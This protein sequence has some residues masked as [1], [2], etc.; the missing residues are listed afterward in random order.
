MCPVK[1]AG[2]PEATNDPAQRQWEDPRGRRR[3]QYAAPVRVAR[4]ARPQRRQ[5]RLRAGPMRRMH[6][7]GRHAGG[8]LVHHADLRDSRPQDN[9]ARRAGQRGA[10]GAM[11]L[12]H[13][14]DDDARPGV[15]RARA[16]RL[17]SRNPRCPRAESLPLRNAHAHPARR[18]TRRAAHEGRSEAMSGIGTPA[19]SRREFLAVGGALI[20]TFSLDPRLVAA[21]E[22]QGG[23]AAPKAATLPGDLEKFPLLDSWIRIAADGGIT[24]FTGKA[25]LGQGIKT[26]LAQIAA[27]QLAVGFERITLI[28]ADTERTPNEG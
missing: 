19:L 13:S 28:T 1:C 25:E 2:L 7:D 24:V 21:Q 20:L 8:V 22:G 17:R 26:A 15:A 12:L 14:G 18:G 9:D 10:G 23:A 4:H 11:R 3:S 27:E 6:G 16:E 5:V